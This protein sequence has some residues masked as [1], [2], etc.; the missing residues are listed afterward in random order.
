MA[1][2]ASALRRFGDFARHNRFAPFPHPPP[3]D[4]PVERRRW[5]ALMIA[6]WLTMAGALIASTALIDSTLLLVELAVLTL[7]AFPVVWRL[8][9]SPF[10]RFWLNHITFLAALV[11]GIIHW[12]LGAFTGGSDVTRL[13]VSYRTL[14]SLFYWVMAFR[15]FSLRNVRDLTQTALPAASGL[16]LVLIAAPTPT[17]IAGTALV[18][19]GTL[20]L[21]AGEHTA[22]RLGDIDERVPGG[23]VKGGAWRPTVNSWLSLLLAAAVA[24]AIIAAVAARYEPSNELAR[25]LRRELAWRL[26]R[27][28]IR[29]EHMPY[30]A[31]PTLTLGGPAPTPQ[32]RLMLVVK[33]ET[34]VKVRTAVYDIYGGDRWRRS[35]RQWRRVRPGRGLWRLPPPEDVG[36]SPAVTDEIEVQITTSYG[37]LGLLPVPY[38]ATQ[39]NVDVPSLRVDRAGM[40]AFSGHVLPGDTYAARVALPAAITARPG[41]APPP[42]TD[43]D[44]TLQLPDSLPQGVRRLARR[45]VADAEADTPTTMAIAIENYLRDEENFTYDLEAPYVPQGQDYVDHFLLVS[46]RGYCNH[47]ASSMAVLLRVLGVPARLATGFTA[48][49]YKP[50]RDVYEVRDQDAHAWVEAFL[51]DTGWVDFDP[52]PDIEPEDEAPAGGLRDGLSDLRAAL[53]SATAWARSHALFVGAMAVLLAAVVIA[54]IAGARWYRQRVLP[55]RPGAPAGDRVIHAYGQAL[56]LLMREGLSRAPS[57]APWEFQRVTA[58]QAPPLAQELAVLTEKYVGARFG[59]GQPPDGDAVAAEAAL[60]RLRDAVLELGDE[61][62]EAPERHE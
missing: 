30:A 1:A 27:L 61:T 38:Y 17:A 56:R 33:C 45:L 11:L 5:L 12:R 9:F 4:S 28:M 39:V 42:R 13:V 36:L 22:V 44:Y 40:V 16:L 48:G 15:A 62:D 47:F 57:A 60:V 7:A 46:R 53:G 41:S 3:E 18:I 58:S 51:P 37:F 14:V 23:R 29:E 55:L 26:A 35:E 21:L 19:G 2:V 8:H 49:E 32:D 24:A 50:D 6:C 43:M 52:T 59:A 34:P 54:A 25:R 10:P 20:A 31:G